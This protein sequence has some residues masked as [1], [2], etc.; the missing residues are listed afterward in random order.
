M[1]SQNEELIMRP[2]FI[3]RTQLRELLSTTDVPVSF[4]AIKK[5]EEEGKIP[6]PK[7]MGNTAVYS[8]EEL[9]AMIDESKENIWQFLNDLNKRNSAA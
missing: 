7:K 6:Q 9:S 8:I 5:W 4:P 3:N 1:N 2:I